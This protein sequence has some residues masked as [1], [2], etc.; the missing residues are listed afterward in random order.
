MYSQ[1][2]HDNIVQNLKI[3]L[4]MKATNHTD[5]EIANYLK[6]T[7]T[8]LHEVIASDTYLS[9]SWDK[10]AEKLAN[11]IESKFIKNTLD[12]LDKGDNTDAKWILER[13]NPKYQK[14]DNINLNIKS[15]DEIIRE[16]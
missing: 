4:A 7:T 2:I 14:K 1:T 11:D 5:K 10:S 12:Q 8:E 3:I 9:E 15:I 16:R 13:T 6:I